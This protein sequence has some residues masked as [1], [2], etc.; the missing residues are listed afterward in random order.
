MDRELIKA[1]ILGME[2]A[3]TEYHKLGKE[4]HELGETLT[5]DEE[6]QLGED[7]EIQDIMERLDVLI[8]EMLM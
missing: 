8:E 7:T 4:L 5:E 3:L 6:K 1:K 2:V